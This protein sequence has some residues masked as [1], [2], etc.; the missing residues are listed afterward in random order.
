MR[1][2]T[3]FLTAVLSIAGALTAS[4]QVYSVNAVG[5]VNIS[6]PRGFSMFAN[7][8]KAADNTLAKLIPTAPAGTVVYKFNPA[9]GS[10]S[11]A[12]FDDLENAWT[13]AAILLLPGEGAFVSAPSAFQNTF[14]GEVMQGTALTTQ[15]P[16][17]FSI[18]S[19]Q[20]PQ[21]GRIDTVLGFPS[22]E[23][24]TIYQFDN[25]TG[26]YKTAAYDFGEWGPVVPTPKVGEA[27]WAKMPAATAWTRD[28]NINTP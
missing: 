19:S 26:G 25:A 5:Y 23:G 16:A 9:T 24:A 6:F 3:L 10:Y 2:K 15:L 28:F 20:V 17:G 27:F 21:E 13:G 8:L 18:A 12:T 1:T 7:P 22:V 11:T 14:V 4:A